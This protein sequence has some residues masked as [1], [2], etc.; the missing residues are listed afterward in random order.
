LCLPTRIP[1]KTPI[2]VNQGQSSNEANRGFRNAG[3]DLDET[4][5]KTLMNACPEGAAARYS[6]SGNGRSCRNGLPLI[7]DL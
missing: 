3:H 2:K 4:L 6:G 5:V 7:I 1:P